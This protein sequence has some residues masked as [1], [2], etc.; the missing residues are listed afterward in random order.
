M[1]IKDIDEDYVWGKLF[2]VYRVWFV[3]GIIEDFRCFE[4]FVVKD[5]RLKYFFCV[6]VDGLVVVFVYRFWYVVC[7]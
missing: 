2:K 1:D 6:F 7:L 3:I 4:V 5:N